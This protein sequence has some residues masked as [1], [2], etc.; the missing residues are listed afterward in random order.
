MRKLVSL[1]ALVALTGHAAAQCRQWSDAFRF[2][3]VGQGQI[4]AQATFDAGAGP[5]LYLG[6][7][8]DGLANTAVRGLARFDGS[9]FEQVADVTGTVYDLETFDDGAGLA[10][11]AA[12][13]FTS[14]DGV[15]VSNLARF[16][17]TSWTDIGG[18]LNG[19]VQTLE[20]F[21]D[22]GGP[23]LF[24]G[25]TF[26]AAGGVPAHNVAKWDGATWS[27]LPGQ[28]QGQFGFARV[29]CLRAAADS[30]GAALFVGGEFVSV[31]GLL[32]NNVA[33]WDGAN[34]SALGAGVNDA[35]TAIEPM[36]FG[37][38]PR[39]AIG[40]RFS[41]IV[42]FGTSY[43]MTFW[44][45]Q[46]LM[47]FFNW[48]ATQTY[49]LATF[50]D[51]SGPALYAGVYGLAG[52]P[53]FNTL[54]RFDGT[55]WSE[56]GS[57]HGLHDSLTAQIPVV[58]SL[59]TYDDGQGA[60]LFC[61][62]D[63]AFADLGTARGLASWD[64]SDFSV[65]GEETS[66][67]APASAFATFDE[68]AGPR[69]F[70][71]GSFDN[72]GDAPAVGLARFDGTDFTVVG[73]AG[74]PNNTVRALLVH[75]DGSG[76]ALYAA[77]AFVQVDGMPMRRIAR[78][79]GSSWSG[80]G[81]GIGGAA[82]S[83]NTSVNALCAYDE[84]AG[85]RLFAAG[86]FTSAGGV[87]AARIARWDGA[88]WTPLGAGVAGEVLALATWNDGASTK[89]YVAGALIAAGG[90]PVQRIASWD[91]VNWSALPTQQL[92]A[93]SA[94][95]V[96][97]AGA[98]PQLTTGVESWNGASWTA[99]SGSLLTG[100]N[101]Q[102]LH[103]LEGELF[104]GGN[105]RQVGV[106][107]PVSNLA[108]F[109]G[110]TWSEVDGGVDGS[111]LGIASFDLGAG[112]Q[113]IV[114]GNFL[115]AGGGESP[116]IAVWERACGC[117]PVV[118]CTAG[119]T[120]NGCNASISGTGIASASNASGFTLSVDNVDGQR[121]G[122]IL[123]G[124]NG[125]IAQPWGMGSSFVCVRSPQQRTGYVS[126]GGT[127]GACDGQFSLDFNQYLSTHPGALGQPFALVTTV[128]A[129]AWFRDPPSPKGTHFSN[130]L[131]FD[132]CP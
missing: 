40:G 87:T 70:I 26:T 9:R 55:Q 10:L 85:S 64:G 96:Y 5:E 103:S 102:A 32:C 116:R 6:G 122:L 51:G 22:G 4:D 16:D 63:F 106:N 129:Q 52:A 82:F 31:N 42:G 53:T 47:P 80:L 76:A 111:V 66:V 94:L 77:G 71:G 112:E 19:V 128:W 27:S 73:N 2:A 100:D 45:G 38:V 99:L 98:G 90:A 114:G 92:D 12:G 61:A 29:H 13:D 18:G 131:S 119:T 86:R 81:S 84:G 34:W 46:T 50:D 49:A 93:I 101:I 88:N 37:G 95:A 132:V 69:L 68:G 97:D 121:T 11:Y 91:G 28:F 113:L 79:N 30:A 72:A 25:G 110:S 104:V 105:L 44:D 130:A 41:A 124:V 36:S 3:G 108:R 1:A 8:F 123:Y 7:S 109:D 14:V 107:T 59:G 127:V 58:I 39:V 62:G 54:R 56:V 60:R 125:P 115:R 33:R 21:D 43:G 23:A 118:Y 48:G 15:T 24:V 89:L 20:V 74:G 67:N 17:G 78:W 35:V 75:D 117:P 126:S 65:Y 120:S 83:P 57:S